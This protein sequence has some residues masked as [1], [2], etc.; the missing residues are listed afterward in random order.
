[1]QDHED[2]DDFNELLKG[3]LMN[4]QLEV[5]W[6]NEGYKSNLESYRLILSFFHLTLC[7]Q[8]CM[9]PATTSTLVCHLD[10]MGNHRLTA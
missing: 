1:M 7:V 3:G 4:R 6:I 2:D 5:T 8:R 9:S 10:M